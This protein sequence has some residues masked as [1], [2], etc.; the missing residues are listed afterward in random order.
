MSADHDRALAA[1]DEFRRH[2]LE[3]QRSVGGFPA[4]APSAGRP[5]GWIQPSVTDSRE[6]LQEALS[7]VMEQIGIYEVVLRDSRR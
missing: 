5:P 4:E 1:L 6:R 3:F 2:V 7:R